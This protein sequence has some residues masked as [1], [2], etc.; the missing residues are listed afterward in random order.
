M[1]GG[2]IPLIRSGPTR[3]CSCGPETYSQTG[4]ETGSAPCSRPTMPP[5]NA[6]RVAVKE[7]LRSLLTTGSRADVV[8]AKDRLQDLVERAAQPETKRLWRTVCRWRKKIEVLVVTGATTVKVD[9]NNTPKSTKRGVCAPE[10]RHEHPSGRTFTTNLGEPVQGPREPVLHIAQ[11]QSS[12][13]ASDA[14][15]GQRSSISG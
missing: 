6:R 15:C 12:S 14:R 1:A 8:A 10:Q 4:P 7:Q 13:T 2:G 9:A 3:A 11:K 5:G